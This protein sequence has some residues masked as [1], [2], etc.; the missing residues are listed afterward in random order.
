[1]SPIIKGSGQSWKMN[2][3]FT[4]IIISGM[5][6]FGAYSIGESIFQIDPNLLLSSGALIGMLS[7]LFAILTVRCPNCGDKW[8]WRAVSKKNKSTWLV[9]LEKQSK[10]PKCNKIFT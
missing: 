10:C 7:F 9:W 2:V 3:S 6:M 1:M 5:L 4:G 8:F